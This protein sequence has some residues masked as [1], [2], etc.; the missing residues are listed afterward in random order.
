M[1]LEFKISILT[2]LSRILV[3]NVFA[4][5]FKNLKFALGFIDQIRP[6]GYKVM[7]YKLPFNSIFNFLI[8]NNNFL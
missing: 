1:I 6:T 2:F 4:E 3:K 5:W 8:T 7:L